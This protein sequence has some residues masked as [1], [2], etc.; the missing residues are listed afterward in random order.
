MSKTIDLPTILHTYFDASNAHDVDRM[1]ACF[2][3]D[4]RVRDEGEDVVGHA[5]I[6][7]WKEKVTAK[8]NTTSEVLRHE[9]ADGADLVTAKVSGTFPGSPIEL[10]YRFGL[11]Q[12]RIVSLAIA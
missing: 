9:I 3:E 7:R 8:Y 12:G 11:E 5:A 10:T 2:A 1:V 4:A 6:R